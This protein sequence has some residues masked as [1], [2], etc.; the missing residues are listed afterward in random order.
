MDFVKILVFFKQDVTHVSLKY[1][2]P[3]YL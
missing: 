1:I 2:L 3:P